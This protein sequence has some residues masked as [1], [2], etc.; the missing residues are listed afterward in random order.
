MTETEST[1]ATTTQ[2]AFWRADRDTYLVD[3]AIRDEATNRL[4]YPVPEGKANR[5]V[6]VREVQD[7]ADPYEL[8]SP[9][10]IGEFEDRET[11]ER[12]CDLI[13]GTA[14]P[15]IEVATGD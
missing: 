4:G 9:Q 12:V 10:L 7:D 5:W 11:A 15:S 14:T 1:T 6:I 13:A 8:P 2:A 3:P